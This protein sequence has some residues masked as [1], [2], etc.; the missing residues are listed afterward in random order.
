MSG[1]V[2]VAA[3]AIADILWHSKSTVTQHYARAQ[4]LELRTALEKIR[5]ESQASNKLLLTLAAEKGVNEHLRAKPKR[6]A[7][8]RRVAPKSLQSFSAREK[9]PRVS[10]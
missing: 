10:S 9:G 8:T 5:E 3:G 2:W 1:G 7:V 6:A 4:L